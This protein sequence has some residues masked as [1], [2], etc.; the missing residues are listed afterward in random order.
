[1]NRTK[2]RAELDETLGTIVNTNHLPIIGGSFFN[3][4]VASQGE[5]KQAN[6]K[7]AEHMM[8]DLKNVLGS[9]GLVH[10]FMRDQHNLRQYAAPAVISTFHVELKPIFEY[11]LEISV[12]ENWHRVRNLGFTAKQLKAFKKKNL[13]SPNFTV[14]QAWCK[15]PATRPRAVQL[16]GRD[17]VKLIIDCKWYKEFNSIRNDL[18]HNGASVHAYTNGELRFYLLST[19]GRKNILKPSNT[20]IGFRE[21]GGADRPVRFAPY[22]GLYLGLLLNFL[23]KMTDALSNERGFTLN[24]GGY[25][26]FGSDSARDWITIAR[27]YIL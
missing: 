6:H 17:M 9:I 14:F 19:D 25:S 16:L 23:N 7:I 13:E 26:D 2:L 3:L 21:D 24:N 1:M 4:F 18:I 10:A 15:D 5:L 22:A 12:R 11:I 8:S 20:P 27:N